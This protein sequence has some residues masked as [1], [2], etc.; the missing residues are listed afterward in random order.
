VLRS[1]T[2]WAADNGMAL[3]STILTSDRAVPSLLPAG[4]HWI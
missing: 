1:A 4:T 3:Q 2:P